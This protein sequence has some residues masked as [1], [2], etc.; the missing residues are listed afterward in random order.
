M[1]K[2][3]LILGRAQSGVLLGGLARRP[4]VADLLVFVKRVL[5]RLLTFCLVAQKGS[6]AR[7]GYRYLPIALT[8][9]SPSSPLLL[10]ISYNNNALPAL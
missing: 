5:H 10:N 3:A 2:S 9:R 4:N 1:P 6:K 7:P 8:K